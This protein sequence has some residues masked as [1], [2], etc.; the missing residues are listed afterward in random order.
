[1]VSP[2]ARKCRTDRVHVSERSRQGCRSKPLN[3]PLV[4]VRVPGIRDVT[5]LFS[6]FKTLNLALSGQRGSRQQP[7]TEVLRGLAVLDRQ[8]GRF[9]VDIFIVKPRIAHRE[10]QAS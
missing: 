2:E 4:K 5:E 9:Q 3:R 10:D 8:G 1:M 7:A 6:R